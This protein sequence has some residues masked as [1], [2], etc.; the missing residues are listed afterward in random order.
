MG[1][2]GREGAE[3]GVMVRGG[4]ER[5]GP[6]SPGTG[7]C[8]DAA[9]KAHGLPARTAACLA[10]GWRVVPQPVAHRE[11]ATRR[12]PGDVLGR[13]PAAPVWGEPPFVRWADLPGREH[14]RLVRR[15]RDLTDE[16][17]VENGEPHRRSLPRWEI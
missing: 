6:R 2:G 4:R 3:R 7:A 12:R 16:Q 10:G 17:T 9:F 11:E 1:G 14:T 15:T 8:G 5:P 13:P